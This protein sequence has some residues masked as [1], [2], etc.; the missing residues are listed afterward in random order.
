LDALADR[1]EAATG[2]DREL[3]ALIRCA[4]FAPATAY[5]A[6]SPFNGAWCIYDGE[7]RD[8]RPR[9][10]EAL[11]LTQVQ[12]LGEFTASLDAAMT[13]VPEGY[14]VA[15]VNSTLADPEKVGRATALIAPG[16]SAKAAEP[17]EAATMPLAICAAALRARTQESTDE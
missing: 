6:M 1:C 17:S 15:V 14:F 3:D 13:L 11:T 9:G 12:R 8:G 4:V 10:W 5:V 2:A 7:T 16:G